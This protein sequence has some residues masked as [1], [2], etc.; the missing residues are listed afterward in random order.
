MI[1]TTDEYYLIYKKQRGSVIWTFCVY[2]KPRQP[3]FFVSSVI[4]PL[5][6]DIKTID[7]WLKEDD[8]IPE[9]W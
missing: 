3:R 1:S 2:K 4:N 5:F 8:C 9:I 6:G 7:G